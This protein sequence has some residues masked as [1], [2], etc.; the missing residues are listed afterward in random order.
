[1][2]VYVS[3]RNLERLRAEAGQFFRWHFLTSDRWWMA[4]PFSLS[5]APNP[6]F[7]RLTAKGIGDHSTDLR[8]LAPGT[9][10]VAEGPYGGFTSKRRTGDK[11]LMIAGGV[12]ITPL[13]ALLEELAAGGTDVVLLYRVSAERDIIFRAEL[14]EL[15]ARSG[16]VV[17]YLIGRRDKQPWPLSRSRLRS[18][19]PDV[20]E[21]DVY[22]CG[23]SGMLTSTIKTLRSL[24][25][26]RSQIHTE[27][28]EL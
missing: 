15:A 5:A 12:G 4:H 17:R 21:R 8:D 13:R 9:R 23:P 14:D 6:R 10:V 27:R 1:V 26:P 18:H 28:F 16:A 22:L 7:L 2:S 24:G 11:V 19:V 20:R 3:G 25:V